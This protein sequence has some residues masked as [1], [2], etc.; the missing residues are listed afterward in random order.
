MK[1]RLINC[2]L[3]LMS[4]SMALMALEI[5]VRVYTNDFGFNNR[6]GRLRNLFRSAYPAAY[7]PVLGWVPRAGTAGSDN[8]WGTDVRVLEDTTRSNGRLSSA[9]PASSAIL[10]VG[11]SFT[12]G[13]E[14]SNH[15]TWPSILERIT[16]VRT[17]NGGVFG[18]G[19]DQSVLRAKRLIK[20]TA[21]ALA[22]LGLIPNDI[23]RTQFSERTSVRKPY[24]VL[25][26][27]ELTLKGVPVPP[28]NSAQEIE[29]LFDAKRLA[30]RS[31]VFHKLMLRVSPEWWLHGRW[32]DKKVH[33]DGDMV[34]CRLIL[35]L[36]NHTAALGIGFLVLVQ[37]SKQGTWLP[38]R[39]ERI[40]LL[41]ACLVSHQVPVFDMLHSL[42]VA[43]CDSARF[44]SFYRK[45][46]HMTAVGNTFTATNLQPLVKAALEDRNG[47]DKLSEMASQMSEHAQA[48]C[49]SHNRSGA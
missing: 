20:Q 14:V 7:D 27:D 35:E 34:S 21:P 6:L 3:V 17:I 25:H 8:I 31:L 38:S 10:A 18:Y 28:P 30:S 2:C 19:V 47:R 4:V 33:S 15:Q 46:G 45:K 29:R 41:K 32:S 9:D 22:I 42:R 1:S 16:G 26:K 49:V 44:D 39:F 12:F 40:D 48:P 37:Y 13:D 43:S 5:A 24:F 23:E 36:A 11:D